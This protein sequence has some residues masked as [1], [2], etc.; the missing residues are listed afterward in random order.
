MQSSPSGR[1][2]R[3]RAC[4]TEN[5]SCYTYCRHCLKTLPTHT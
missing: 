3:C 2:V 4:G 5:E 1:A